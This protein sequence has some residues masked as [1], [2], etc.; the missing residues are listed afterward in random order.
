MKKTISGN[1]NLLMSIVEIVIGILLLI[2]PVGF[3]SGIIVAFGIVMM[4]MGVGQIIK[5]FATEAEEAAEGGKFDLRLV[6]TL[7]GDY[8]KLENVGFK[9]EATYTLGG[10]Q[11]KTTVQ[12][13]TKLYN[14]ITATNGQG[15]EVT[16]TEHTAASLGGDYIFVLACKG[17]PVDAQNLTFTVTTFYTA[18][19]AQAPVYSEVEV[20]EIEIPNDTLQNG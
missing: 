8:A 16:T 19:G 5:Y 3:T 12:T 17:L 18:M 2:N 13:V 7:S 20:V 14:S 10:E 1:S 11:T 9:V 15:A 4:L 6:A